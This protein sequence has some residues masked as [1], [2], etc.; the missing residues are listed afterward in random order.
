VTSTLDQR[1][2]E[3]ILC[4][5]DK[6][7]KELNL[8]YMFITHNLATVR[9]IVDEV[10]VMQYGKVGEQGPKDV[11]FR[12]PHHKYTDLLLSSMPEMDPDWL[13]TLLEERGVYDVGEAGEIE[14]E[15]PETSRILLICSPQAEHFYGHYPKGNG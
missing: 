8:A 9:S 6:L 11:M 10:V 1:V 2:A 5:L 14:I 12:P 15:S 3:G 4:L 13:S 7:Q